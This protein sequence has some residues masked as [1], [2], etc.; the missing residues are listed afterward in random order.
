MTVTTALKHKWIL[1]A[2]CPA[3]LPEPA[4]FLFSKRSFLS[5]A[6]RLR[7]I[8]KN[9]KHPALTITSVHQACTTHRQ[10]TQIKEIKTLLQGT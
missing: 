9:I 6:T 5:K 8:E 10:H 7:A 1:G 2:A 4:G 3:H